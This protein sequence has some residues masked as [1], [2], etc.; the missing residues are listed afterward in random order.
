MSR[1]KGVNTS[2]ELLLR[3]SL[4]GLGMRY[5][6]NVSKL[7]GKPDIVFNKYKVVIFVDGEFWHGYKWKKKR[8]RI[9]TNREY[10]VKKIEGNMRRDKKNNKLLHGMGYVVLRF[11]DSEIKTDLDCCLQKIMAV[12]KSR[13]S[14]E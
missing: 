12:L 10:W 13:I 4:Y 14:P 1:I 3:K 6:L 11:W 2:T 9:K 7:P 5:R 8:Q